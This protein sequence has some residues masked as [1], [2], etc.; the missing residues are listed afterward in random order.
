MN[1][2]KIERL[3]PQL[4][5]RYHVP[6]LSIALIEDARVVF[7]KP[8]GVRNALSN[9][10][11]GVDTVFEAASLTKPVVAYCALQLCQKDVLSLDEPLASYLPEPYVQD[12][13]RVGSIN[14][15]HVLTHT[16]GFPNWRPDGEPLR[17]YFD[18]GERFSYSG[19]GFEYL[20]AVIADFGENYHGFRSKITTHSERSDAG[21][22]IIVKW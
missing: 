13:P 1:T 4:M 5:E 7:S 18:P 14:T 10:P 21:C 11:I 9:E 6:G 3:I 17:V 22:L 19:E 12:E 15:R 8:Y 20:R 16:T 2:G